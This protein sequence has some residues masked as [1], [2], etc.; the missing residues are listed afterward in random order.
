MRVVVRSWG[1]REASPPRKMSMSE[2][3][4]VGRDSWEKAKESSVL[5]EKSGRGEQGERIL[6][7]QDKARSAQG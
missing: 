2:G 3:S 4:E 6:P 7:G 1:R 5:L